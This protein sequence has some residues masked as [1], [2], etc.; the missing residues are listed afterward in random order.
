MEKELE[1]VIL[2]DPKSNSWE[3][4]NSV[5]NEIKRIERER[6]EV[7][8]VL[9]EVNIQNFPDGEFEPRIKA[10]VRQRGVVFIHDASKDPARWWVELC[11]INNAAR[12]GSATSVINVLPYMRWSRGEK[13]DKPHIP[14][15]TRVFSDHLSMSNV[16]SRADRLITLDIHAQAIQGFFGIPTD[17]LYSYPTVTDYIKKNHGEVLQNLVVVAPDAGS[18]DRAR[19]FSNRL[20]GGAIAVIDKKR[21]DGKDVVVHKVIGDVGGKNCLLVDDI[22]S[23]GKTLK[24]ARGALM[25]EGAKKIYGFVTHFVGA[26]NYGE[27]LEGFDGFFSTDSFYH[28]LEEREGIKIIS[29]APLFAEVIYRQSKGESISKLFD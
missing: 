5:Y 10:N 27:N 20:G 22:L 19:A 16:G 21:Q 1:K 29:V 4:A 7:G 13:K 2:A 6:G 23:S 3:F 14:I 24:L 18:T 12:L 25:Q 8:Y 11:L 17:M 15:A 28:S 26:G 9:G